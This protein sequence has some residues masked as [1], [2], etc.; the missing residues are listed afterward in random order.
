MRWIAFSSEYPSEQGLQEACCGPEILDGVFRV[1]DS[2]LDEYHVPE[3]ALEVDVC[4]GY[5]LD[6]QGLGPFLGG[7]SVLLLLP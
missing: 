3:L 6:I 2:R 7:Y 1:L 5:F 4:E